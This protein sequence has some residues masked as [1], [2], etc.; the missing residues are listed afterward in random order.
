MISSTLKG[1]I[2]IILGVVVTLLSLRFVLKL[3]AANPNNQIVDWVYRTSNELLSPLQGIF[4]PMRLRDGYT[5]EFTILLAI[6]A[7]ALVG[8]IVFY[9]IDL[10][11][12]NEESIE[13]RNYNAV[14]RVN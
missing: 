13:S 11:T 3:F 1:I 14:R 7:Y 9:A 8:V 2:N 10:I 4:E 12:P 5:I 6:L